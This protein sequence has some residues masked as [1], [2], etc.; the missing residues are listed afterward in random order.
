MWSQPEIVEARQMITTAPDGLPCLRFLRRPPLVGRP[1]RLCA[2]GDIGFHGRARI[3]GDRDGYARL[4]DAIA[5]VLRSANVVFG[6]LEC[7][8][9][10]TPPTIGCFG[11]PR[12]AAESLA[13]ARFTLLNLANNHVYDFGAA[14][15]SSTIAALESAGLAILGAGY[16]AESARRLVRTDIGGLRIGWLGCG[17][18][19]QSQAEEGPN[20]WEFEEESLID[21]IRQSRKKVDF[22]VASVHIGYEY[23]EVP[24]SA[25]RK[26]AERWLNE[27]ADLVLMHHSHVLEGIE[28][29]TD[30]GVICYGLGN[31]IFD[32]SGGFVTNNS[33]LK[34]K[35]R[36]AIFVF[37]LDSQGL[38]LAA[39]LPL[40]VDA[41]FRIQWA[42]GSQG[43]Q[44]LEHFVDLS[45]LLHEDSA[46]VFDRQ[47][48]ERNVGPV[49]TVLWYHFRHKNW[50][51][52]AGVLR[53]IRPAN[54]LMLLRW[55][56]YRC[57]TGIK[58]I[59]RS[60]RR[61]TSA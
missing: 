6:N 29:N 54:V 40:F 55:L 30:K 24:S 42:L 20:F 34:E 15:C 57:Y 27:G 19:L 11:G 33:L 43:I 44:A 56:W 50:G 1:V 17:R 38:C 47:R 21:A 9:T 59:I 32:P 12:Q 58:A 7:A 3:V 10:D 52:L 22:L 4:F 60:S 49:F 36:G 31:L 5:P 26:T 23:I 48:A 39:I 46:A 61:E 8:L 35:S 51:I 37:D 13:Q 16:T 28:V 53:N 18:T 14:G 2:V 25:R 41:E 45:R